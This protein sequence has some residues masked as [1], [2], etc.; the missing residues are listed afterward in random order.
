MVK[1]MKIVQ[2]NAVYQKGS[3]GRTTKELHDYLQ[4]CGYDSYVFVAETSLQEQNVFLIGNNLDR[5]C[6][7]LCS[8]I[9]GLQGYFSLAA[10]NTLIKQLKKNRPDIVHLR[11]LHGNYINVPRLLMFLSEYKI[12]VVITLHDC[13]FFTGMCCYY[14][15]SHCERWKYQCG[16]CPAK[17][18]WNKSWFFDQSGKMLQDK[19]KFFEKID[20]LAVIG[21]SDW[22]T[23]EAQKSILG[24]AM[25]V[26]RI[27][28]WIDL[29]VFY[30]R[31]TSDLKIKIGVEDSFVVLGVSQV[32][33]KAKGIDVFLKLAQDNPDIKVLL[34]GKIHEK[35]DM[36]PNVIKI[37]ILSDTEK[38]AEMYSLADVFL[39]PSVQ[40]TFGKVTAESLACGTPVIGYNITATP[41]LIGEHCGI[42]IESNATISQI[43]NAVKKIRTYGK[44]TYTQECRN[45]AE[46]NFR[47]IDRMNEYIQ[48]YEEI[49][50]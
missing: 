31:D 11:N 19:R 26:K 18:K 43:E 40:E 38:L 37:G 1:K 41:E 49:C 4:I 23:N 33:S 32:W 9:T 2:I 36:P 13:W 44:K 6:H 34:V 42:I 35:I 24:S 12:P 3:T 14:T 50:S 5:K 7:A 15:E 27:Y 21:V 45:F 29:E 48:L 25:I 30:P 20:R 28:N 8:R 17:Y 16:K 22:V 47:K 10:T 46:Q 39:N